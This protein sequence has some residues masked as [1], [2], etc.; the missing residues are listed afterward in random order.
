VRAIAAA[1]VA[2]ACLSACGGPA[3]PEPSARS[4][5]P[6]GGALVSFGDDV[7][8]AE[9]ADEPEERRSGL[10]FRE[11]L[12]PDAGMI[13]LFDEREPVG[14]GFWMKNTLIPLSIAYM[15]Q[16]D[17]GFEVVAIMDM[18]PCPAETVRCPTYRPGIGYDATLE[19]NKGWFEAAGVEVGDVARVQE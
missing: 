17:D 3:P 12:D 15:Q 5:A 16:T 10:M 4:T 19:V 2:L 18:V 13:F 8:V 9:I 7:V 6:P 14:S 1:F 11:R